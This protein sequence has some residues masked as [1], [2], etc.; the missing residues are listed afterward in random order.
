MDGGNEYAWTNAIMI[1][2][3]GRCVAIMYVCGFCV[4][5]GWITEEFLISLLLFAADIF[6]NL[7]TVMSINVDLFR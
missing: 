7:S 6:T 3:D 2:G 1:I 5:W 4:W